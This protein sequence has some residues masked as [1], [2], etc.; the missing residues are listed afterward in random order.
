MDAVFLQ[1]LIGVAVNAFSSVVGKSWIEA[2]SM[3][4]EAIVSSAAE[5]LV[6][7]EGG[8]PA[9]EQAP[10][11]LVSP[12][13]TAFVRILFMA[14]VHSAGPDTDELRSAFAKAYR[15][16]APD[17]SDEQSRVLFDLLASTS[18]KILQEAARD[19]DPE[20]AEALAAGRFRRLDEE[21]QG[22][23]RIVEALNST[24]REDVEAYL[25]WERIYRS[26]VLV[27][28]GTITPPSFDA[29]ERVSVDDIYVEPRFR[30]DGEGDA[31]EDRFS[32][33]ELV[34]SLDRTVVLGDPGAGKSTFALKLAYDLA[35]G[36]TVVS[37]GSLTP[38]VVSLKD[39]GE[40][41]RTGRVSL[42]E[43]METVAK[44]DYSTPP[45]EGAIP[46]LLAAGRAV[47]IL[48]GRDE[49]LDTSDRRRSRPTSRRLRRVIPSPRCWSPRGRWDTRRR[50][51][52]AADSGS[53]T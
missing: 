26:Q 14:G 45:P 22:L 18:E 15:R 13:A 53:P 32:R 33:D 20:A 51:W 27:R 8:E 44:T 7:A 10:D 3:D 40:E 1:L 21:I 37:G 47:V 5:E 28:H 16:H 6:A 50:P 4:V 12:E 36:Q 17:A 41:K 38:L 39:Y 24:S 19:G 11:F 34:E 2:T 42:V 49:L 23:R 30:M 25:D 43:W 31:A 35:R 46:Y 52:I 9:L 48:D 29:S